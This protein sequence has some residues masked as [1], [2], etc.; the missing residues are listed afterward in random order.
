MDALVARGGALDDHAAT[1]TTSVYTTAQV[2]PMLPEVLST[3]RTSLNEDQDRVAIVVEMML[4]VGDRARVR[5]AHVDPERGFIDF[6]RA[7]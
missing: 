5:L 6:E 1:N 7:G 4:D 3:N 2:F